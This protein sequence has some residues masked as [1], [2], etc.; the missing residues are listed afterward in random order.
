LAGQAASRVGQ[1]LQA[2]S[3]DPGTAH[4][5]KTIGPIAKLVQ[6]PLDLFQRGLDLA[7]KCHTHSLLK[8]LG[9]IVGNVIA[10]SDAFVLDG[11]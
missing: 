9:A 1:G 11:L 2:S 5:A 8:G 10:V 6:S 4:L 3:I 7:L